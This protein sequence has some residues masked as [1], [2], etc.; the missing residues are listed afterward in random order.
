MPTF[1]QIMAFVQEVLPV[2]APEVATLAAAE[3]SKVQAWIQAELAKDGLP[4]EVNTFL[5][6]ID[7]GLTALANVE[8]AKI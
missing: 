7:S 8:I 4:A 6:G 3:E 5:Q 1:A 2:L